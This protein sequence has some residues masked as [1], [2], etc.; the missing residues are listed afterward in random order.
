MCST[1]WREPVSRLS[2]QMTEWPSARR[3]SQRCEPRNPAPPLPPGRLVAWACVVTR[4]EALAV[5]RARERL[6][7]S[8]CDEDAAAWLDRTPTERPSAPDLIER[9]ERAAAALRLL[10]DLKPDERRALV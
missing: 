1:F 2:T 3:R 7:A 9:R 10:A 8:G 5:R 4:R 6:L